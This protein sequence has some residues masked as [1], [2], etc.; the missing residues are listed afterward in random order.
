MLKS[1]TVFLSREIPTYFSS[2]RTTH[3][4]DIVVK[5][6]HKLYLLIRLFTVLIHKIQEKS[7]KWNSETVIIKALKHP[8]TFKYG[9]APSTAKALMA[10]R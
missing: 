4:I 6:L 1:Y 9:Q 8:Q 5:E 10:V 2:R 7:N 3:Y